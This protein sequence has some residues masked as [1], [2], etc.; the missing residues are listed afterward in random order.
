VRTVYRWWSALLFVLIVV[1]VGFAGYGAFYAAS[2]LDAEGS[3]IDDETFMD[4]FG[5]HAGFGYLVI[6]AG[7]IFLVIGLI[8][9]VGRWR[10]GRHGLLAL[11]LVVQLFLA[12]FGSEVPVIGSFHPIN[13]LVIF[14]V[15][16]WTARDEWRLHRAAATPAAA[17]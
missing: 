7:L 2:K 16:G 14:A 3:T 5:L 8:A 10:L 4:G 1:Q 6:L 11:L 9:G 17:T 15:A 13:A 12:W